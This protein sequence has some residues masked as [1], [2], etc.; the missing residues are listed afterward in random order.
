MRTNYFSHRMKC[1]LSLVLL[2]FICFAQSA[3]A[4]DWGTNKVYT[5]AITAKGIWGNI[6]CTARPAGG[7]TIVGISLDSKPADGDI[8]VIPE[9]LGG[10]SVYAINRCG[11]LLGMEGSFYKPLLWQ[12]APDRFVLSVPGSLKELF[13]V[14]S[15][16]EGFTNTD[17]IANSALTE[18]IIRDSKQANADLRINPYAFMKLTSLTKV[19]LG[20]GVRFIEDGAFRDVKI[21]SI[22]DLP[23]G[24][25]YV[26]GY[27]FHNILV[28]RDLV[29]PSTLKELGDYVFGGIRSDYGWFYH[30]DLNIPASLKFIGFSALCGSRKVGMKLVIPEGVEV[31][32]GRN[33]CNTFITEVTLPSTL[34]E[35]GV[36][37]FTDMMMLEKVHFNSNTELKTLGGAI[38]YN[39]PNLRYVD[40]SK[41]NSPALTLTALTRTGTKSPSGGMSPYTMLY[42][43]ISSTG[44]GVV[45][46]GEENFVQYDGSAWKC[47]KFAV[48]DSHA[49]YLPAN[50]DYSPNFPTQ[51]GG[52]ANVSKPHYAPTMMTEE[53]KTQFTTWKSS[54]IAGRGCDY[55]LPI[56][57]T[58]TSAVYKRAFTPVAD[59]LMTVSLPY[60]TTAEQ[61]GL[62]LFKLVSEKELN[63]S[64]NGKG[65]FFLSLDDNRL[66]QSSL[67][68][69]E[70]TKCAT[71]DHAYLIK[72]T[73]VAGLGSVEGGY[74]NLFTSE[75]AKVPATP[76]TYTV[77]V[78]DDN[79]STWS[80]AGHS[81]NI[82][83]TDAA[84][85]KFYT[86][87]SSTKTWHPI[88]NTTAGGFVHSF[89]GALQYTGSNP[90][91]A[92][93]FPK[94][95]GT[96]EDFDTTT[97]I[98]AVATSATSAGVVYSLDGR[99]LGTS[100]ETLPAGVYV[101][102][103][104]KVMK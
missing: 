42:L 71:A 9:A 51:G 45:A 36:A 93:S 88:K 68:D 38:F 72:V 83:N 4:V 29:L 98:N 58:A 8:I 64:Y 26:K 23:E 102:G 77:T 63:G 100:L 80:F 2:S 11:N 60:C 95:V 37:A 34:K 21:T 10:D 66:N 13:T 104:K 97:G 31:I 61:N 67:T 39:T 19:T 103:G 74:Y 73:D 41:V 16:S 30:N 7:L 65:E 48:Y 32:G 43:P 94:V 59:A 55:E 89:R 50:I 75:N 28:N 18:L 81:M 3:M 46:A 35:L 96:D 54:L 24:L 5:C 25:E 85:A 49:S 92:Q 40:M 99:K 1:V 86:F 14:S 56:A 91:Y 52:T 70:K 84:T 82:S 62:K 90:N 87:K 22:S 33:F 101:V 53:E 15:T 47:D 6:Y 27:A 79:K 78:A 17:A 76:K 20:K 12:N 57:F 69:E 44:T